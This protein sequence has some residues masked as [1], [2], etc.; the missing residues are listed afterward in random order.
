MLCQRTTRWLRVPRHGCLSLRA[1]LSIPIRKRHSSTPTTSISTPSHPFTSGGISTFVGP[2]CIGATHQVSASP[3]T[4]GLEPV[5]AGRGHRC[6]KEE[7]SHPHDRGTWKREGLINM[8]KFCCSGERGASEGA[9]PR[10]PSNVKEG[11]KET[12]EHCMLSW[13][14]LEPVEEGAFVRRRDDGDRRWGCSKWHHGYRRHHGPCVLWI[15]P[16]KPTGYSPV[17]NPS[18]GCGAKHRRNNT[19]A[20][21]T[22]RKAHQNDGSNANA[23]LI[24]SKTQN[25]PKVN[26]HIPTETRRRTCTIPTPGRHHGGTGAQRA[27]ISG[28]GL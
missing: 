17:G 4:T 7:E 28:T 15:L 1:T 12:Q 26:T 11:N 10:T 22:G 9:K 25:D 21:I 23:T 18:T 8:S 14:T 2:Q 13:R 27:T 19:N 6:R 20:W 24:Y 16:S 5:V 3:R